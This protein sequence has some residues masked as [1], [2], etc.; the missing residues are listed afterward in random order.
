VAGTVLNRSEL[1]EQA[2]RHA[3]LRIAL[4]NYTAQTVPTLGIDGYAQR[5]YQANQAAI[6]LD[7]MGP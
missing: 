2:L 5:I 6:G 4:Q 7:D 1:I 3:H